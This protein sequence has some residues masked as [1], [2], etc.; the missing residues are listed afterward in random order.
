VGAG[1]PYQGKQDRIFK[2][3]ETENA[4]REGTQTWKALPAVC[5]ATE[6]LIE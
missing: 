1:D 3:K 4:Q 5:G 6:T 2:P